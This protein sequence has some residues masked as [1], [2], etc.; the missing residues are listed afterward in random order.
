MPITRL[1]LKATFGLCIL[2][3]LPM[4]LIRAQPYDDS[5]LRNFLMP[6]EDCPAPCFMG[7]QPGVTTVDEAIAI[8]QAHEWVDEVLSKPTADT[9]DKRW[10]SIW[11]WS[12]LQPNSINNNL[13]GA[14][15]FDKGIV[16]SLSVY[17]NLY[18]GDIQMSFGSPP[19]G[20]LGYDTETEG[21]IGGFAA[22]PEKNLSFGVRAACPIDGVWHFKASVYFI[23]EVDSAFFNKLTMQALTSIN[24]RLD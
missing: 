5:E 14:I 20:N 16:S 21:L 8:L 10:W 13:S 7:I 2:F 15:V 23:N 17:T 24:R 18:L 19:F 9:G 6:P 4:I 22:Y 1:L 3:T 12:G 11:T